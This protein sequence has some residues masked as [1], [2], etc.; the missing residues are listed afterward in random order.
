[1]ARNLKRGGLSISLEGD[2]DKWRK[3]ALA[4]DGK[5]AEA[6]ERGT[7]KATLYVMTEIHNRIRGAKYRKLSPLTSTIKSLEGFSQTPLV[8]RGALLRAITRDVI[9]P[10]EGVVGINKQAKGA[11]GRDPVTGKF[12]TAEIANVA[13]TLHEGARIRITD[14]MKRA[15]MR[16]ITRLMKNAGGGSLMKKRGSSKGFIRIP[17][18]PFIKDVFDDFMVLQKVQEIYNVEIRAAVGF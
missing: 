1:M 17:P 9:S 15:F 5:L 18:R 16:R 13:Y 12:T 2:W 14:K 11:R 4:A 6:A 8:R 7:K 10:Y 3:W